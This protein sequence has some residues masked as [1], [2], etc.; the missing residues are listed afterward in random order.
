MPLTLILMRHAKS[1]WGNPKLDDFDRPLN[2]RGRR[3]APRVGLW[4][5]QHA[6]EPEDALCSTAVRAKQTLDELG[7][8]TPTIF[9]PDLYMATP[10]QLMKA[11]KGASSKRLLVIAHNPGIGHL[12]ADLLKKTPDHPKFRRYPTSATTVADFE[13]DD[14]TKIAPGTGEIR[15][16]IVP[17]DLDP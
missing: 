17:H 15:H 9:L 14:W 7:L 5:R 12:A 8:E 6:L 13:I 16:F 11:I 2:E 4:L 1:S 3:D 10:A